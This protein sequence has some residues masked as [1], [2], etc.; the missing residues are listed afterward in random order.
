MESFIF[1]LFP[2]LS[3]GQQPTTTLYSQNTSP[4]GLTEFRVQSVWRE[5]LLSESIMPQL[6]QFTYFT[7]FFWFCLFFFTFYILYK[8]YL[9]DDW[10]VKVFLFFITKPKL[11][12]ILSFFQWAFF[13][14]FLVRLGFT[15]YNFVSLYQFFDLSLFPVLPTTSH[16]SGGSNSIV[17]VGSHE[18]SS[19]GWTS[20]DLN[21][22]AEEEDEVARP[23]PLP[24]LDPGTEDPIYR[25]V[26]A[27]ITSC[28]NEEARIVEK[29]QTLLLKKG[30][31]HLTDE[32]K[33]DI[34][35]AINMALYDAWETD[36]DRRLEQF[37]RIR[38]FL[39]T[40]N[41]PVW[42]TFIDEMVALGN[43][44][45]Q[46]FKKKG[47]ELNYMGLIPRLNRI[48][49]QVHYKKEVGPQPNRCMH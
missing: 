15:L 35:R 37:R 32:D 9:P 48:C 43:E 40:G 26:D 46:N 24:Q 38:R 6:D 14:Y 36:I 22:L 31:P 17:G 16:S 39:G 1:G 30:A 27:I 29:A 44:R 8:F 4:A 21:V 23:R 45:F 33:E 20:F 2:M 13:Y 18:G 34:R 7:Q 28:E 12:K 3:V 47:I 49:R 25:A 11:R 41:S 42:N 5:F 19:S 10:E